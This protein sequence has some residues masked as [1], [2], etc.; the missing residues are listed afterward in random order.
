[1]KNFYALTILLHANVVRYPRLVTFIAVFKELVSVKKVLFVL[2]FRLIV[3]VT[4]GVIRI[5]TVFEFE[6]TDPDDYD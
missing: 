2:T 5:D 3:I 1:M 4:V 6:E